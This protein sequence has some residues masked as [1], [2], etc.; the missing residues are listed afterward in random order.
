MDEDET[1][2]SDAPQVNEREIRELTARQSGVISAAQLRG[3]GAR[4]HDVK[5]MLRRRDLTAV[6]RGVYV[7]HTGALSWVQRAWVAVLAC[8]P[9][10]L[11]G[12]SALPDPGTLDPIHVVVGHRRTVA[13]P[14]GVVVHRSAYVDD[15][16]RWQLTP[17]RVALEHAVL[18]LAS[19]AVRRGRP[20][21]A[22]QLL[23]DACQTKRTT[24]QR[25]RVALDSRSRTAGRALLLELIADLESGA[26]SVLEREWLRI[27][28]AHA[29][30]FAERQQHRSNASGS[31]YRDADYLDAAVVVELDGRAFHDTAAARDRDAGRDLEAAAQDGRLTVRLTYG[32]VVRDGCRTARQ[33]GGLMRV[34]GWAGVVGTCP[35]CPDRPD[36]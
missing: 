21:R 12:E 3:A 31:I 15:R 16:V 18:D 26:C 2:A 34:R 17:P 10:A 8:W 1:D 30:P 27:E 11:A 25:I 20:D 33:I 19:A 4:P 22:F 36:A 32:L 24:A 28:R 7:D 5:R 9:A 14:P 6:H 35:D 13:A 23:A 29:L